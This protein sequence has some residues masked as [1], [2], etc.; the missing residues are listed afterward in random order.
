MPQYRFSLHVAAPPEQVFDLWTDVGRTREWVEGVTRVTG[1]TGP[2]TRV[3]TRFTVWFGPMRS[4]TEVLEVERP[5]VFRTRFGSLLLR[6]EDRAT[7]EPEGAGTR[8]TQQFTIRGLI[9]SVMARIFAIGSYKGSFRGELATFARLAEQ[10]TRRPQSA[11]PRP[12]H[13]SSPRDTDYSPANRP[14]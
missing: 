9:P 7:F 10:E 4:P 12:D 2:P 1:V 13:P 11:P 6:G 14:L 3:G 8:L 5:R